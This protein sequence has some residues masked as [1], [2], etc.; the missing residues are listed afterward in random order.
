[1]TGAP[2]AI[3]FAAGT[4]AV[5]NPC[6]FAMLPAY[7]SS[8]LVGDT[9]DRPSAIDLQAGIRRAVV[10]A[11]SVSVGFAALFAIVGAATKLLAAEVLAV[12]PWVSILIGAALVAFGVASVAGWEPRLAVPRL[13]RGGATSQPGSM[14]LYG[15]SYGIVSLGCT[16]PTFLTYVAGT[17]SARSVGA[18]VAVFVAY[19]AGFAT[20]LTSLTVGLAFARRTLVAR[21]R[22]VLPHIQRISGTLLVLAGL[23]VAYYGWYELHRLGEPDPIVDRV[24]GLSFDL[25]LLAT[26]LGLDRWGWA[27]AL[28]LSAVV[29]WGARRTRRRG[30]PNPV[31]PQ[32]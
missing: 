8:F 29:V 19:A 27:L 31:A 2:I 22:R 17:M 21:L 28:P 3:G 4:F 32:P 30:E 6:G 9:E 26:D 18:G 7:L 10:V 13:D 23:Y 11:L 14:A 15:V 25:Q 24:T 1:M 12:S 20:L 5:L 16:L